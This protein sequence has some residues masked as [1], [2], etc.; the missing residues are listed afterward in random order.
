MARRKKE[1]VEAHRRAIAQAAHQ[2]FIGKGLAA[3]TV[4]M[5][6]KAAGYSKATLYVYFKNK[7]E[8]P[9]I[10]KDIYQLGLEMNQ[11]IS[12]FVQYG[13][14][15]NYLQE[16]LNINHLTIFFW[17]ALSGI[18]RMAGNKKAY[19]QLLSL[20]NQDFLNE[21]YLNLLLAFKKG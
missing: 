6:A 13:I 16:G 10:Y 2:L 21:E 5:I 19:Y 12:H 7:E 8:T 1:P 18:I 9:Q 4:D 14:E 15:L 20:D 17:S 3:T 11:L